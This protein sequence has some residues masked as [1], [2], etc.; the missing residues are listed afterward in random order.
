[1]LTHQIPCINAL[2]STPFKP[3]IL[4]IFH[5][6]NT[7]T[8]WS[9]QCK[10]GHFLT[11]PKQ[12]VGCLWAAHSL[13]F[14]NHGHFR[15]HTHQI[16]IYCINYHTSHPNSPWTVQ[17][18]L[19]KFPHFGLKIWDRSNG[20]SRPQINP[21]INKTLKSRV[22]QVGENPYLPEFFETPLNRYPRVAL[23]VG[24]NFASCLAGNRRSGNSREK[25]E[26]LSLKSRSFLS[27]IPRFFPSVSPKLVGSTWSR[28]L[29]S[30][31]TCQSS[32]C[33]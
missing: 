7:W 1:M 6:I 32:I 14:E 33:S 29:S 4:A 3:F 24:S 17:N 9:N 8:F 10:P 21:T 28:E 23:A 15:P 30:L 19:Q 20:H 25:V 11:V 2:N 22:N 5:A 26:L 13:S 12:A 18:G 31:A 16:I 27:P